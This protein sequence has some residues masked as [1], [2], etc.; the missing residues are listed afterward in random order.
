MRTTPSLNMPGCLRWM[1][2]RW[3]SDCFLL[4][5]LKEHLSRTRFFSDSDV[6]T[7]AENWFNGQRR[8][9]YQAGLN[10]KKELDKRLLALAKKIKIKTNNLTYPYLFP[11]IKFLP[12]MLRSVHV[13][14]DNQMTDNRMGE[15]ADRRIAE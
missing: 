7:A 12:G 8:H 3:P 2:S 15:I 9:F 14:T 10:N 6:K 5:K 4:P 13:L 1:V 11:T